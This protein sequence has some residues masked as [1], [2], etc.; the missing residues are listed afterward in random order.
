MLSSNPADRPDMLAVVEALA[1]ILQSTLAQAQASPAVPAPAPPPANE[2]AAE[3]ANA[4]RLEARVRELEAQVSSLSL[5]R[6][7]SAKGRDGGSEAYAAESG[8]GG[9]PARGPAP[10]GRNPSSAPELLE[11]RSGSRSSSELEGDKAF[12]PK[13][14]DGQPSS[15]GPVPPSPGVPS[16]PRPSRA[17]PPH[18][19]ASPPNAAEAGQAPDGPVSVSR[20]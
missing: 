20:A 5:K 11:P 15:E 16:G 6:V 2:A 4:L 14:L 7:L 13:A 1:S 8:M 3:R 9:G 19:E 18:P 10:P 12:E 17:A